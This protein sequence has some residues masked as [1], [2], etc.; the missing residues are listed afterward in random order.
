MKIR[1][2]RAGFDCLFRVSVRCGNDSIRPHSCRR[3]R[4]TN[5][6]SV[7]IASGSNHRRCVP[8]RAMVCGNVKACVLDNS[9]LYE[10]LL[11]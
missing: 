4:R 8:V 6:V 2:K 3:E 11:F 5:F 9:D 7:P 10:V 1:S